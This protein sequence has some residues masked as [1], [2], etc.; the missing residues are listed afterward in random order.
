MPEWLIGLLISAIAGGIGSAVNRGNAVRDE[1]ARRR[2]AEAQRQRVQAA[3]DVARARV[4][5]QLGMIR[6]VDY[7]G[8]GDAASSAYTAADETALARSLASG[9]RGGAANRVRND[10]LSG[11][12]ADLAR[13]KTEDQRNREQIVANVMANL[14]Q[15]EQQYLNDDSFDVPEGEMN[16]FVESLL[17]MLLGGAGGAAEAA[18]NIDWSNLGTEDATTTT[19]SGWDQTQSYPQPA[20]MSSQAAPGSWDQTQSYPQSP[21][22]PMPPQPQ[23]GGPQITAGFAAP[24]LQN[25]VLARNSRIQRG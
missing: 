7:T 15:L 1:N 24:A 3:L 13:F 9:V 19:A 21:V 16:T 2:A 8:V 12:I 5:D 22:V 14:G 23:Q 10:V 25:L 20:V 17:A 18:G 4:E 6:D 11:A